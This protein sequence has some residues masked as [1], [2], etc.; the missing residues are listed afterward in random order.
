MTI[1]LVSHISDG[2]I[3]KIAILQDKLVKRKLEKSTLE[4]QILLRGFL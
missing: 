2:I 4:A 1:S 3:L